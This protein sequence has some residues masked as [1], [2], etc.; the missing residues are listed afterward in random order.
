MD[1]LAYEGDVEDVFM[2]TFQVSHTGVFGDTMTHELKPGGQDIPVTSQN[3][4][5]IPLVS[6]GQY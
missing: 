5:V 6:C 1:L 2:Q 4:Q 3:R